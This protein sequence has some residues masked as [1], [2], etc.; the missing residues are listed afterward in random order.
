MTGNVGNLT[1]LIA[2]NVKTLSC[3][4][5]C[6]IHKTTA[7]LQPY[8]IFLYNYVIVF[9]VVL[10]NLHVIQL[11]LNTSCMLQLSVLQLRIAIFPCSQVKNHWSA[12]MERCLETFVC[13]EN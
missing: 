3:S 8:L 13:I 4:R 5:S 10:V 2:T 9:C 1:Q 12:L 11:D 7:L 6:L